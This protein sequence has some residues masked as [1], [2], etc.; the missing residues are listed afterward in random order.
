MILSEIVTKFELF[1]SSIKCK[2]FTYSRFLPM[3][4]KKIQ[5]CNLD[6]T[7]QYNQNLLQGDSLSKIFLKKTHP[8]V[9]FTIQKSSLMITQ[10]YI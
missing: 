2:I 1:F 10:T 9:Y 4:L 7:K 5:H 6:L 8:Q 3:N